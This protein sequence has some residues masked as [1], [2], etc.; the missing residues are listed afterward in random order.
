[1]T[2]SLHPRRGFDSLDGGVLATLGGFVLLA[3]RADLPA[4]GKSREL[5]TALNAICHERSKPTG[6]VVARRP[7][8][9]S[10]Q[11]ITLHNSAVVRAACGSIALKPLI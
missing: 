5:T 3:P 4:K 11:I 2:L 1:L 7:Q 6:N 8:F 9:L 10:T